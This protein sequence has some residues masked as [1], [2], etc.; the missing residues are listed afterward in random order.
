MFF[1]S[2]DLAVCVQLCMLC[3]VSCASIQGRIGAWGTINRQ[4]D[5][6]LRKMRGLSSETRPDTRL[7]QSRAGRQGQYLSY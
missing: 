1:G 6:F 4:T 3:F 2:D 7:P 5:N